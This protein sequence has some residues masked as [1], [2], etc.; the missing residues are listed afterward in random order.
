MIPRVGGGFKYITS[1]QQKVGGA[2]PPLAPSPPRV[3]RHG[4][5]K[6]AAPALVSS[7]LTDEGTRHFSCRGQLSL[8]RT[9]AWRRRRSHSEAAGG[10]V[11]EQRPDIGVRGSSHQATCAARQLGPG[12]SAAQPSRRR[13]GPGQ[14]H[15]RPDGGRRNGDTAL[16]MSQWYK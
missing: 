9:A 4:S 11:G 14:Q 3:P 1:P 2:Q 10:R 7:R 12:Q 13:P 6:L 15:S 5:T 8:V 16:N